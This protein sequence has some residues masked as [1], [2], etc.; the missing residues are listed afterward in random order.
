MR[1]RNAMIRRCNLAFFIS[2]LNPSLQNS[3]TRLLKLGRL[4]QKMLWHSCYLP[5]RCCRHLKKVRYYLIFSHSFFIFFHTRRKHPAQARKNGYL[6]RDIL[7]PYI[8]LDS[9]HLEKKG[10]REKKLVF[11]RAISMAPES[12][13]SFQ[14]LLSS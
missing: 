8:C 4:E 14:C 12:F 3:S 6:D 5:V 1:R 7:I 2:S 11:C 9:S 13:D 10:R